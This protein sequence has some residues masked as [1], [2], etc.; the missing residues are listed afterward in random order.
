M[1]KEIDPFVNRPETY[2]GGRGGPAGPGGGGGGGRP[3][4]L[5]IGE[6]QANLLK[7]YSAAALLQHARDSGYAGLLYWSYKVR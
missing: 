2:C 1:K 3:K 6:A 7:T 4:P 5:V